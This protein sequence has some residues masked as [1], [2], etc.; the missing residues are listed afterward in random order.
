[1]IGNAQPNSSNSSLRWTSG[2]RRRVACLTALLATMVAV[3]VGPGAPG[4]S[5][6]TGP[7][8]GACAS[9]AE[10]GDGHGHGKGGGKEDTPTVVVLPTLVPD[11]P[12]LV[13]DPPTAV[14]VPPTAVPV[15]PTLVPVPPTAVPVP[16]TV[17][18]VPPTATFVPPTETQVPPTDAP[19]PPTDP[20]GPPRS[21]AVAPGSTA[22]PAP[23]VPARNLTVTPGPTG[24]AVSAQTGTST[25]ARTKSATATPRRTAIAT[26]TRPPLVAIA[27]TEAQQS[28]G[29]GETVTYRHAVSNGTTGTATINV[30]TKSSEGWTVRVYAADGSTP[31]KDTNDDGVPDVGAVAPSGSSDIVVEVELPDLALGGALDVTTITASIPG[32]AKTA[33]ARD[34]TTVDGTLILMIDTTTGLATGGGAD[35]VGAVVGATGLTSDPAIGGNA[36]GANAMGVVTVAVT[37]TGPWTGACSARVAPGTGDGS[38]APLTW[39][40]RGSDER[41]TPFATEADPACFSLH[42]PGDLSFTYEY[43][44]SAGGPG[45]DGGPATVVTY[46]VTGDGG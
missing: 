35:P 14:P 36:V 8:V 46:R 15:P 17:V 34:R 39:R 13:P 22:T 1:M 42:E 26:A 43:G 40:V 6:S 20:A 27:P 25:P 19:V 28:A 21:T 7:I 3:L 33:S 38:Q 37:S 45:A 9:A 41:W 12:T 18:P 10:Y 32:Y 11:P 5:C 29:P 23:G 44:P 16:P 2:R 30:G 4:G 31:L 24:S